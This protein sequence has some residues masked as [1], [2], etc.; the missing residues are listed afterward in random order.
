MAGLRLKLALPKTIPTYYTDS[1]GLGE[2]HYGERR[3][4]GRMPSI[5]VGS[6]FVLNYPSGWAVLTLDGFQESGFKSG[7][8]LSFKEASMQPW[9]HRGRVCST[10]STQSLKPAEPPKVGNPPP[11]ALA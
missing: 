11:L 8:C 10:A 7:G 1:L 2:R 5:R 6:G 9:M 4:E 3:F